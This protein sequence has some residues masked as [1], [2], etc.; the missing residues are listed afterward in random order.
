MNDY[1]L[2]NIKVAVITEFT[3]KIAHETKLST[4]NSQSYDWQLNN[5]NNQSVGR[6]SINIHGSNFG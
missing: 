5:C 2:T 6:T 4:D 1:E 3:S